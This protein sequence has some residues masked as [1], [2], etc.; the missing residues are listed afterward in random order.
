MVLEQGNDVGKD[1]QMR[2]GII[3]LG[4]VGSTLAVHLK[5]AGAH[6]VACDAFHSKIDAIR[7]QGIRLTHTIEKHVNIRDACYSVQ[8]LGM[9][10]LDLVIVACKVPALKKVICQLKDIDN[11][12]FFVMCAQN[13]IDNEQDVAREFGDGRTLRMV[14]N[15]AGNMI[16]DSA[17]H[18]SFFNPPNY[19]AALVDGG[20][21]MAKYLVEMLN[22]VGL[23]TEIPEDIQDHVWAKA[24]LNAALS[25]VCA[26][27]RRTMKEVMDFPPTLEL[28]EAIIDESVAVAEKE[29]I[30]LGNKFT[31]FS[32]RYLKNA[33]HH[34]PS[35]LVDL[36]NGDPTEIDNL[37]GRIAAYGRKHCLPTPINQSVTALVHL[38]EHTN[39]IVRHSHAQK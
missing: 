19:I 24:I 13:G 18:V 26:I 1:H 20:N 10:D 36:E 2:V 30:D 15:Y 34:R 11:G 33:G 27:T 28:V 21:G 23:D 9:Y 14:V 6:V 4:P 37:N 31:R 29:R 22:S 5:E 32:I 39:G 38:L 12:K 17:V 3:G 16:D 7:K 25:A 8:E 35:M